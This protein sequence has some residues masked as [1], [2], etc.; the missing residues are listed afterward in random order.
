[1]RKRGVTS[2]RPSPH[3]VTSSQRERASKHNTPLINTTRQ[4][5]L[6]INKGLF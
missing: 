4:D 5:F 1:M 6:Y 2:A 3:R